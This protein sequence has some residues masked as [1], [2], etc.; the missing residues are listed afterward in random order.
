MHAASW[1]HAAVLTDKLKEAHWMHCPKCGSELH[2]V[3]LHGVSVD[4]CPVCH[5]TW[6]DAGELEHLLQPEKSDLFHRV[7]SIFQHK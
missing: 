5:G 2:T 6:L 7:M 4:T 3:E 1:T